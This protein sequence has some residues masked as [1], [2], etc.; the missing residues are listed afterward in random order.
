MEETKKFPRFDPLGW[1]RRHKKRTALIL[2][3]VL[4]AALVL[5]GFLFRSA[6]TSSYQFVRTTT[7]QKSNLTERKRERHR[8][9]RQRGQRYRGRFS[10]ELQGFGSARNRGR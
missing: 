10:Q 7:L 2:V 8:E 1:A 5:R 3:L 4:A 6:P 9:V